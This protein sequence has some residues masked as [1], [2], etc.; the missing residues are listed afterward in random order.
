MASTWRVEP[1][2]KEIEKQRKQHFHSLRQTTSRKQESKMR[3]SAISTGALSIL[4]SVLFVFACHSFQ[5]VQAAADGSDGSKARTQHLLTHLTGIYGDKFNTKCMV[6]LLFLL[7]PWLEF[8]FQTVRFRSV[9]RLDPS[10]TCTVPCLSKSDCGT[11]T[12][13]MNCVWVSGFQENNKT[14]TSVTVSQGDSEIF[15]VKSVSFCWDGNLLGI[16]S[17]TKTAKDAHEVD[18]TVKVKAGVNDHLWKQCEIR[19][20]ALNIIVL[21]VIVVAVICVLCCL[22]VMCCC[23]VRCVIKNRADKNNKGI[24]I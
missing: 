12:E 23:V 7:F 15:H 6:M 21:A 14:D 17:D 11:C 5:S 4:L 19:Q 24:R 16:G 13:L 18:T 3:L 10:K 20:L 8:C 22:L 9:F 2:A 1:T